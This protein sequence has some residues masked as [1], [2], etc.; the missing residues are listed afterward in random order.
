MSKISIK[1]DFKDGDKLFS[2]DLNNNFRVIE[3][4]VN[5]NEANLQAVIDEA[6][7]RLDAELLAITANRGWDWNTGERVIY[8]KGTAAQLL[9]REIINGQLLV[10]SET[11][12]F[13]VD[14]NNERKNIE[15]APLSSLDTRVT[16]LE[17]TVSTLDTDVDNLQNAVY[18][19]LNY[20]NN[21]F[22]VYTNDF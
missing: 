12:A 22:N 7:V 14:T 19:D 21:N 5:A 8:Y 4:G 18:K 17:G 16:A 10:N 6:I 2:A 1:T 20:N 9:Q 13:Y 3:A 11:G 15:S